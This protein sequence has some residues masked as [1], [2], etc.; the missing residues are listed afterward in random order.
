MTPLAFIIMLVA[1]IIIL[2]VL[3][4]K[5]KMHPV[6]VLFITATFVGVTSGKT[7]VETFGSIT[8]LYLWR[9]RVSKR[10]V[11]FGSRI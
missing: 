8:V 7:L 5:L 1:A 2:T 6:M 4:L 3:T 9:T 11:R 10:S